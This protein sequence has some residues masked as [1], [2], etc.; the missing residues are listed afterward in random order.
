MKL[1]MQIPLAASLLMSLGLAACGKSEP[2]AG[3]TAPPTAPAEDALKVS[4]PKDYTSEVEEAALGTLPE[5][6]G[7]AVGT[8]APDF[9]AL[10]VDGK[11]ASLDT[12]VANGDVLLV[13]YRGGW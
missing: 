11:P 9:E 12:L 6:V 10:D 4:N 5:G 7:L 13:F 1:T 2:P 8:K 3:A